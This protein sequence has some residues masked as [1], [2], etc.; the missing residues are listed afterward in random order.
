MT[1]IH[2]C[3]PESMVS[4]LQPR[5]VAADNAK[6]S[7]YQLARA[8]AQLLLVIEK[9]VRDQAHNRTAIELVHTAR[10]KSASIIRDLGRWSAHGALT[11]QV[12]LVRGAFKHDQQRTS[13]ESGSRRSLANN[14]SDA[15]VCVAMPSQT[16]KLAHQIGVFL[17]I[18]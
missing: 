8:A 3:H 5:H 12:R 11:T 13:L 4:G 17:S 6:I 18:D 9:Q 1:F 10:A 15:T 2:R 7:Q 16:R 14:N